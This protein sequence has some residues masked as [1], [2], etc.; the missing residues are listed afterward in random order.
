MS[1]I[2]IPTAIVS[3]IFSATIQL[4]SY[5]LSPLLFLLSPVIYLG[6]LALYITLL[7]L[8]ILIRLEAFIYFMTGAVLIG[9][10]IG[11]FLYFTG[12]GLSHALLIDGSDEPRRR[13]VKREAIDP[14]PQ[15]PPFDYLDVKIED[16]RYLP[17]TI[18]EEE[19]TSYDSE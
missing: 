3:F 1:W 6:R 2:S 11:M 18:L 5:L 13:A 12:T 19:E 14:V 15:E 4:L 16:Q 9:A 7:P 10:T 17:S 8:R